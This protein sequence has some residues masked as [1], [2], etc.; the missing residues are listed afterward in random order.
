MGLGLG[1]HDNVHIYDQY[2]TETKQTFPF[3]YE[4]N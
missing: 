3:G 4:N 1:I 2:T